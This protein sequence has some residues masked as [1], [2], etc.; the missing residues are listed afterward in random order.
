MGIWLGEIIYVSYNF[1]NIF[2]LD[3]SKLSIASLIKK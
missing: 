2:F 1:L 3:Y